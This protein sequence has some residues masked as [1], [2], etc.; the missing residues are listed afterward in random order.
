MFL[1]E[2]SFTFRVALEA[3]FPEDYEGEADDYRW[4][5]DWEQRIKPELL[6]LIM[7]FLRQ[8]PDWSARV[9]NRGVSPEDEI[10]IVLTREF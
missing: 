7:G 6:K 5:R 1:E 9:R 2:K 10:E 4:L 3:S 8:H